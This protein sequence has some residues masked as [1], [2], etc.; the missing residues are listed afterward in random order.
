MAQDAPP[1]AIAVDIKASTA[2][3]LMIDHK[4]TTDPSGGP[5]LL[6][7]TLEIR[8]D[9]PDDAIGDV[10]VLVETD[11]EAL[12]IS[13]L[14]LDRAGLDAVIDYLTAARDQWQAAA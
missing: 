8:P 12:H 7:L 14:G 6:A 1:P 13:L 9:A 11:D 4:V 10:D 3:A 2:G 5:D